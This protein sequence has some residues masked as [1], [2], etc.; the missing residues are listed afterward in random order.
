MGDTLP[1]EVLDALLASGLLD[2]VLGEE[3]VRAAGGLR[4]SAPGEYEFSPLTLY[5]VVQLGCVLPQLEVR[6]DVHGLWLAV[7]VRPDS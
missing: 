4:L 6:V 2:I 1:V 7:P 5:L 3:D